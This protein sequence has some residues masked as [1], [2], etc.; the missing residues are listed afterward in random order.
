MQV[1]GWGTG[2]ALYDFGMPEK[3]MFGGT[4]FEP[5]PEG[6]KLYWSSTTDPLTAPTWSKE[7]KEKEEKSTTN[8]NDKSGWLNRL[9]RLFLKEV[10]EAAAAPAAA[11]AE[12]KFKS[13]DAIKARY[14]TAAA[15]AVQY[16]Y[17]FYAGK[18][19]SI[20]ADGTYVIQFDDGDRDE[21]VPEE[22]VQEGERST[23]DSGS[24]L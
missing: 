22:N 17:S 11:A 6:F 4:T 10:E 9:K 15:P 3:I 21:K 7:A 2:D 8:A 12:S 18:V 19:E 23:L 16:S 24:M 20:N 14:N 13:G 1:F 5:C